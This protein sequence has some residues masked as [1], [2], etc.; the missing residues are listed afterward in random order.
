MSKFIETKKDVVKLVRS[1]IEFLVVLFLVF[2]I[3]RA[4]FVFTEYKP[5]DKTDKSIVSGNDHGFVVLSYLGVD[6]EG[7]SSLI[8]TDN[9]DEQLKAMSELGY[10]TITQQD[11]VDYYKEGKP[12]PDKALYLMF[13]DGRNDTSVFAQSIMEKYNYKASIYSYAEKFLENDSK[14][15][16][17]EDLLKLEESGF[18]ELGTNGY[19]L[20]YINVFDRYGRFIGELSSTEYSA[21]ATYLGKDYNQYL[22]DFLRDEDKLPIETI[23]TMKRRVSTEYNLMQELYEN[24]MN[25]VPRAYVLMHSNTG[26]FG[27]NDKVSAAN[28][29]SMSKIF[30]MNFNREGSAYNSSDISVYDLTRMQP[31]AYWSANHM[32]MRLKDDLPDA[33][34]GNI[35]FVDGD[36]TAKSHW[37]E[38][39]GTSQF[40]S[41][42]EKIII[43]SEPNGR[44]I[45]K[46]RDADF[47]DGEIEATLI[48]NKLGE[49]TIYLRGNNDL[50]EYVAV[51]II[52]NCVYVRESGSED[53]L[54]SLDLFDFDGTKK[55]SVDEDRRDA[56]AGE[57]RALANNSDSH[58]ET[59]AYR[60]LQF[61][62]EAQDAKSVEEGAAEY[63]AP[64]QIHEKGDRRLKITVNGDSLSLKING[65]TVCENIKL[66]G[67]KSGCIALS[68]A[69]SEGGFSQRSVIDNVYDGVFQQ[70]TI[71]DANDSV[72]YTNRALGIKKV[73]FSAEL[74]LNKI[75]NW[76]IKNL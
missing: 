52:D 50:S 2:L 75:V 20:R 65:R 48:G 61:E 44:G 63:R 42:A 19:R 7:T 25:K 14:F 45:I 22:M 57:Y 64:I 67:K 66:S 3:I 9:L 10:V 5:Y 41:E 16:T 23:A 29:D 46:Y 56:L 33:D 36:L 28:I 32:L 72:I 34:K 38:L 54:F 30:D 6:R 21:M 12:L 47:S 68:S 1:I 35:H 15:L 13:E 60:K 51:S 27:N 69:F 53:D 76:F 31:Q 4:M 71:E 37:D 59:M 11:I 43:T 18:W 24:E 58:A 39:S 74:W 70:V 62:A 49:Q 40:I 17:A 73:L 8:S 55:V 26:N